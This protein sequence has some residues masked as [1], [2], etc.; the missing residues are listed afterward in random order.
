MPASF[1]AFFAALASIRQHLHQ[2]P[3]LSFHEF[4][5]QALVRDYL[6]HEAHIPTEHIHDCATTGLVVDIVG[7]TEGDKTS[8]VTCI[9]F[10]GDMDALPMTEANPHLSYASQ[11][12]QVA[13]MC[14]HDGHT[15]RHLLPP[16]S[17]VRL[18]F[19][20][21]EE[22]Y[23]G[24]PAMIKDGCLESVQEI[25]GYHNVPFPLGTV[26]VKPGAMMSHSSRFTI[27][28]SGPGGHGS[29]PHETKDPIVAAGQ[30]IVAM[31]SIVS[32]NVNAHDSAIVSITQVHGGEPDNVIPSV[33]TLSGRLH[34]FAPAVAATVQERMA[35]LVEHTCAAYGVGGSISFQEGYPVLVN[36]EMETSIVQAIAQG[37]VGSK[38]VISKGC[39]CAHR[40][41]FRIF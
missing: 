9:A 29:A 34:D 17:V 7:P 39:Q 16:H 18:L 8:P 1:N 25:Y 35:T 5:T 33:V 15:R 10:R 22:C 26:G 31:Q 20:P 28:I 38:R 2:H 41:I 36:P 27:R 14:G 23:F 32:R 40:K 30:L 24:A 6:V 3:E 19:Q 11:A 21:A 37:I 12:P 13:H 4:K